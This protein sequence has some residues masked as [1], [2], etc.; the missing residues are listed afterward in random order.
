VTSID[1][2]DDGVKVTFSTPA[3]QQVVSASKLIITVQPKVELLQPF[4]DLTQEETQLFSQFNNSYYYNAVIANAG[5]P[6]NTSIFSYDPQATDGLPALPGI[7]NLA[8]EPAV[9]ELYSVQYSSPG[10][11]TD[12]Y[13]R[14][15]ILASVSQ[16]RK[17]LNLPDPEEETKIIAFNN[18]SPAGLTV[19]VD[20]IKSGFFE[21]F[22]DLQGQTNTFWTGQAW[23]SGSSSTIWDF[24]EVEVLPAVV[25]ALN[26]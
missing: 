15:D 9:P 16:S 23:T 5:L 17:A 4:L 2:S 25:A 1:R 18:H 11:L 10:P 24:T 21:R 20:A 26:T 7:Y 13:V 8:F 6:F 3:G 14:T 12:D 19:S 22:V